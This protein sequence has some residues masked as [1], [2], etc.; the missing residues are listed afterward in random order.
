[1]T[2]RRVSRVTDERTV[3]LLGEKTLLLYLL[4]DKAKKAKKV[5][6]LA[7]SSY[8]ALININISLNE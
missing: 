2:D 7:S 4:K 6:L 8:F 3:E 1:M 5:F